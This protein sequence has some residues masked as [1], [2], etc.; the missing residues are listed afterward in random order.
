MEKGEFLCG[1][2]EKTST[3]RCFPCSAIS[4]TPKLKIIPSSHFT[5]DLQE[6]DIAPSNK[7]KMDN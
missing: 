1:G 4:P 6:L 2:Y 3:K 5:M 7:L